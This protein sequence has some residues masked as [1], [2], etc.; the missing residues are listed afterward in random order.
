MPPGDHTGTPGF[1]GGYPVDLEVVELLRD[2][3]TVLFRPIRPDDGDGLVEFHDGLSPRS[4]YR[5]F[6]F[7]HPH[8]SAAEVERFTHVDY[9]D[10]MAYVVI[11]A[12]RI[13]AV[14]RYERAPGTSEAEVAFVV[15]DDHQH[16]G[17]GTLLLDHLADAARG[18][19]I[20]CFTAQTLSENRDML[21]VFLSS[22]FPVTTSSEAGTVTVRFPIDPC[23]DYAR[24]R[25]SR[26]VPPEPAVR[27][28]APPPG[29]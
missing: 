26:R 14:G 29:R 28:D 9:V 24:A 23:E 13:V 27:A 11:R 5:R 16:L 15:T 17:I 18:Y 22:G 21:A 25:A 7:V 19:G 2:G 12:G 4:V 6:F 1:P 10:R 8:L 20:G 3:T